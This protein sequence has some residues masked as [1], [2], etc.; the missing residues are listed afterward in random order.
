M[1]LCRRPESGAGSLH[2]KPG[3]SAAQHTRQPP[4]AQDTHLTILGRTKDWCIAAMIAL[5]DEYLTGL[6]HGRMPNAKMTFL[7]SKKSSSTFIAGKASQVTECSAHNLM[8]VQ[9]S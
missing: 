5:K 7:N 1:L 8:L 2:V 6:L 9:S 4:P 3:E